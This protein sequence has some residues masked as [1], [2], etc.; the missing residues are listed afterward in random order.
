MAVLERARGDAKTAEKWFLESVAAAGGDPAPAVL[1]WARESEKE[2]RTA[3]A[4]SV[5]ASA[6]RA[7][8]A[9]EEIVR[10]L[11]MEL[12]RAHD[13]RRGLAVLSPFEATTKAPSTFNVLA[14]LQTCLENR[15][16][17]VRLLERSLALNPDQPEVA[18]SLSVARDAATPPK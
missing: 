10:A 17:V 3:A 18:R 4:V 13:C 16:E 12:F 1:S 8:P 6:A 5:L 9:N 14:L 11:A 7:Y 15:A 2:G